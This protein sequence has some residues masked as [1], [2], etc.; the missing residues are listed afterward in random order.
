MHK[1]LIRRFYP[2]GEGTPYN[3]LYA[4]AGELRPKGVPFSDL[5]YISLLPR[6]ND[7]I[8]SCC[9]TAVFSVVTQQ[10]SPQNGCVTDY[11]YMKGKGFH[12]L[13]YIKG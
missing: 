2:R 4:G 5:R 1:T 7:L 9:Y 10:S 13:K 8:L 12:Q 3:D 6:E 11:R